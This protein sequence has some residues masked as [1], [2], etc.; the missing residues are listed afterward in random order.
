MKTVL[1]LVLKA[2]LPIWLANFQQQQKRQI[3]S[4]GLDKVKVGVRHGVRQQLG[5]NKDETATPSMP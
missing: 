4:D 2:D 1:P 5:L 3:N